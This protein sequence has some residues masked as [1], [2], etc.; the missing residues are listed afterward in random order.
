MG[1][2][3]RDFLKQAGAGVGAGAV[4]GFPGAVRA[5][6]R[7]GVP[8]TPVKIGVLPIRAGI[9]APVGLPKY[10]WI[11]GRS[12][13][14]HICSGSRPVGDAKC[15]IADMSGQTCLPAAIS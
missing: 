6:A 11:S 14:S 4:V 12:G 9:A 2:S 8:A 5:Q 1:T 15:S 10:M 3:R 7:P 13:S